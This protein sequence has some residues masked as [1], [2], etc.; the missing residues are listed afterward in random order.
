MDREVFLSKMSEYGLRWY[1]EYCIYI[2]E[3]F[4]TMPILL[5]ILIKLLPLI[6]L[7][8]L[9]TMSV[10][11]AKSAYYAYKYDLKEL[12]GM[13]TKGKNTLEVRRAKNALFLFG[14]PKDKTQEDWEK[15]LNKLNTVMG[16]SFNAVERTR[17]YI[18]LFNKVYK[19]KTWKNISKIKKDPYEI[20]PGVDEF[21]KF[22][23]TNIRFDGYFTRVIGRGG[24]GK[25]ILVNS[26]LKQ[27]IDVVDEVILLDAKG[28]DFSYIYKHPKVKV[29][30]PLIEE[31]R[32][33]AVR[34][35]EEI[36]ENG[37]AYSNELKEKELTFRDVI[38]A[39]EKC[40]ELESLKNMK[41]R[42][43]I[44]EEAPQFAN[45]DS[46]PALP[47]LINRHC[48]LNRYTN[49]FLLVTSQRPNQE[50]FQIKNNLFTQYITA[51]VSPLFSKQFHDD[52]ELSVG[53]DLTKGKFAISNEK[54]Q[55][56]IQAVYVDKNDFELPLADSANENKSRQGEVV[57]EKEKTIEA[58]NE[59]PTT[60]KTKEVRIDSTQNANTPENQFSDIEEKHKQSYE[61]D[62]K[63]VLKLKY[64]GQIKELKLKNKPYSE[65]ML[66]SLIKR[67]FSQLEKEE[68]NKN[69][70]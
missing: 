12:E 35:F 60:E 44:A 19:N 30:N 54:I 16:V 59:T 49:N 23:K 64:E 63:V 31:E 46:D 66:I 53:L 55:T 17:K 69:S 8:I 15:E 5:K 14:L 27:L 7:L 52:S 34:I 58:R 25:S 11:K 39:K 57:A 28:T 26:Y 22:I 9:V 4:I 70:D 51:N 10:K 67:K 33:E 13:Y 56:R 68:L 38:E 6:I 18:K 62:K 65:A 20:I 3:T 42:L 2:N 61:E 40:P 24:T 37:L 21:G 45:A 32:A 41:V 43:I 29:L 1:F 50:N 47:T 48:E 36:F